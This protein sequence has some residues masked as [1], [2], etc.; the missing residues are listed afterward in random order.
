[1]S[2]VERVVHCSPDDVFAVLADGWSYAAWVVGASR[3]R[4][5][6]E[7]WPARGTHI[8]HSVGLWPLLLSDATEVEKV[9]AP[10]LLELRVRAFPTGEGRV[11]FRCTPRGQDTVVSM[12]ERAV[13]GPA[14]VLPGAVQDALLA[15]RNRECLRRLSFIAEGRTR[16]AGSVSTERDPA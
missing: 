10:H 12:F 5:V 16:P 11:I 9:E 15:P 14:H 13:S 6:D 4:A 1:M 3:I 8:Y 7:E 2:R